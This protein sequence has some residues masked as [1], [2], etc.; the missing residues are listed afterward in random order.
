[1]KRRRLGCESLEVR[2]LLAVGDLRM[3][4]YNVLGHDG[5]PS[6]ELGLVL[7]AI[8]NEVVAGRSRPMDLLAIQESQFQ[9]TTTANVVS[10]LNSVYGSGVYSRGTLNGASLS[11]DE[12][13]GLVYNTQTLV[14]LGE[15]GIGTPSSSG[16]ARQTIR[17]HL[18]PVGLSSEHSFYVY[19]SH[20]KANATAEDEA[21]RAVE[22]TSIRADADSL[23]QG[24]LI[25]YAGDFNMRS[26]SE[27]A[28]QKLLAS[29]NGQALDPIGRLGTWHNNSSFVDVFTQAPSVSPPPGFVGGGLDDRFDFQLLTGEWF[30][31]V[32]MEYIPG[33]YRTF[34]NNG[35]VAMN[36]SINSASSSALPGL[37][38]RT[39]IL[40][41]LTTVS[42]HLPVV[43]DYQLGVASTVDVIAY[44]DGTYTQNFDG[45]P[46]SGSQTISGAGPVSLN[47]SPIQAQGMLG[48]SIGR[49]GGTSSNV[50][51]AAGNG[52]ANSG[53]IQSFGSIGASERSL[54]SLAS[55][56][57]VGGFGVSLSNQSGLV[58]DNFSVQYSGEWWRRG[59]SG[60]SQSLTF[61][62]GLGVDSLLSSGGGSFVDVAD[63]SFSTPNP[64]TTTG[65]LDGN[66]PANRALRQASVTGIQWLPG[67]LLV[68]RWSDA[69]DVGSDDGLAIDEFSF[70]TDTNRP[71]VDLQIQSQNVSE[72]TS[73]ALNDVF[74]G[75]FLTIDEDANESFV[76]SL[77][78]GD[79]STHNSLFK[80]VADQLYF[81]Q[82]G[83]LDYE[84][85]SEYSLRIRVTDSAGNYIE[86]PMQLGIEDRTEVT[87]IVVQGGLTQR[88]QLST[89]S[90][91]FDGE[92]TI[93]EDAFR[94]VKRGNQ[95]GVVD[96]QWHTS[97]NAQGNTRI[98]FQWTGGLTV[99]GALIDG[100][101]QFEIDGA[102]IV[103]AARGALDGDRN[104]SAGGTYRYG[105]S[106]A[107]QFYRYFGDTNGDR[108][109]GVAEFN[110][111]RTSFGLSSSDAAYN[112]LFDFD[113]NG[114]IS[115][116]DFNAFRSRFGRRLA[117]E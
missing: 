34:G 65:A 68:L 88:S 49:L 22:A 18:Q 57:F 79:S 14:L 54:G 96:L 47:G 12:T 67:Q 39:A 64:S 85:T 58:I 117:F 21:R 28:F 102:K 2:R 74:F 82:G 107:D 13:V 10:Q 73:S 78:E 92:V 97:P 77:V 112:P 66:L 8:G 32:G 7:Q 114:S 46:N 89:L 26:S 6:S 42:D 5:S 87:S 24:T 106:E 36:Q 62:Y 69:N 115:S 86:R 90:I 103:H 11:G 53:T 63:L 81:R 101:Y 33:S 110:E 113:Q 35:S 37:P 30:D 84:S 98:D 108:T 91:E 80:V 44:D 95:G 38:N 29:G 93:A 100:N 60:A 61:S 71:P 25:V 17:Y 70:S 52:D 99:N 105:A 15:V 50:L 20:Y 94:L 1:M 43:V 75:Q 27:A 109:L 9:N 76:Y 104:G 23:G 31:G 111:L 48:W 72:N 4:S 51:F 19:N 41:L 116:A 3:V 59:G 16:A 56:S 55:G 40:N 83:V 45:L